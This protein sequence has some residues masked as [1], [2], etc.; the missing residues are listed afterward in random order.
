M[1]SSDKNSKKSYVSIIIRLAI[2]IAACWIIY[3]NINPAEV[4]D[5]FKSMH[6]WVRVI[7]AVA[8]FNVG[9]CLIGLRWWV[10]MRAQDIRVPLFLAIKLTFLGQFFT[11][12]LPSAVGGDVIRAWY[13]SR[14]THK[15]LQAALG[16]LVDRMMGL[17]ATFIL[18]I[19]S[20][21]LFM[22]GQGIFQV[23]RKESGAIG[24]FFDRH[25]VSAYQVFLIVV[26]AVGVVLLGAGFF[27]LKRFFK[28]IY[29]H[30]V[31]LLGQLKEVLFV[32]YHHPL[33]LVFG[34]GSTI[35]LQSLVIL[36]F[37]LV[38]RDLGIE[39]DIRFYF[40]FFPLVWVIGAIPISIAGIGVLEGGLVLLFFHFTGADK[41]AVAALALCQ[42]LT[43]LVASIP[44]VAVHLSGSHRHNDQSD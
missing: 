10:F 26:I 18:A 14:H 40:I 16:V 9:L 15:R 30:F 2:A 28:R 1:P 21:L 41:D 39:A 19:A 38:G 36:S 20:Y 44:G 25:P 42:R 8:V 27:D 7:L 4:A 22:R 29:A 24:A 35:F 11:N 6:I 31:H 13:V 23:S 17:A 3:R 37:W 33:V 12:F 43:W 34:L 5:K 32:Y